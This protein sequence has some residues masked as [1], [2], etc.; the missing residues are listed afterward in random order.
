MSLI[1]MTL[2]DLSYLAQKLISK[3]LRGLPCLPLLPSAVFTKNNTIV[4]KRALS[5]PFI[6]SVGKQPLQIR[7]RV[8]KQ[9]QITPLALP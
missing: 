9:L 7:E 8:S 3:A 2:L 6:V 4:G 1:L 5:S